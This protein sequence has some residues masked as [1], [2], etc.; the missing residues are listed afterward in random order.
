[1]HALAAEHA[2]GV[3][4]AGHARTAGAAAEILREGGNAF[5]AAIAGAWM[6]CVCEPV[7]ASP[8]GGGFA[9]IG[10]SG[11]PPVLIDFFAHTPQVQAGQPEYHA[12]D[13]DFGTTTQTFHIG[14]G[15]SATP[16]FVPGLFQLHAQ[17]ASLPMARLIAPA[18]GA[19]RDGVEITP[20]QHFLSTVVAPIL[21]ASAASCD[22]YAP[23]GE[24]PAAGSV[25][26]N[27]G[28]ADLLAMLSSDGLAVYASEVVGAMVCDQAAS[29]HLRQADF[30]AYEVVER[31]P[32]HMAL[33][34]LDIALN[35]VPSACGVLIRHTLSA[36]KEITPVELAAALA[37]TDRQRRA[38][39][40]DLHRLMA[41]FGQPSTRGTTHISVIS[42]EGDACA[43]T[44]SN[45]EGN[46][47][48]VGRF[49]FMLN[50]MLGE[51]DVNPAGATGW[52][53]N[54]RL[55]SIMCPTIA[56]SAG[57]TLLALG[58]GGSNRIRSAIAGVLMNL[59]HPHRDIEQS[60]NAPRMHVEKDHLD[61]EAQFDE[62][63]LAALTAAFPDHRVWPEP[64]MY[65]G[66]C[67]IAARHAD[68]RLVGCGDARRAG[69]SL[70]AR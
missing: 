51:E 44:L 39:D 27:Q 2:R 66:G 23:G 13:A 56:R 50:N 52:P 17:H 54:E 43:M 48:I 45:G 24:F 26:R 20:Y 16:G 12:A 9:M 14:H 5:D 38:H 32:L 57:G 31:E 1:M 25:F 30:D 55:S 65:F 49:G 41:E 34:D 29:G 22:V 62:E 69:S 35:P 33:G 58:S 8:G 11:E 4:A 21:K 10:R 67:H 63:T 19:A 3:V 53:C 64:S 6:A 18:L 60:V 59:A 70:V 68:G 36:M 46:G 15:A 61:V 42:A 28:L 37:N 7:L 47:H 40:G